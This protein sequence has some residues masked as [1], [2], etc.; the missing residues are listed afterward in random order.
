MPTNFSQPTRKQQKTSCTSNL[1]KKKFS[2]IIDDDSDT[3]GLSKKCRKENFDEEKSSEVAVELFNL[4]DVSSVNSED[5]KSGD[6][7]FIDWRS[8]QLLV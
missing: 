2:D 1:R 7:K 5:L 4:L 8:C 6:D 3:Q